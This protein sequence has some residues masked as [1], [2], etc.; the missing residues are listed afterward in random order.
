ML[1][2][3]LRWRSAGLVV[4]A[5]VAAPVQAIAPAPASNES[6]TADQLFDLAER[7]KASSRFT[8]AEAIYRAL[9]RDQGAD[10]R[11]EARFRLGMM[12]ASMRRYRA[13]AQA[14]RGLLDEKPDASRVRLEL[15]R[16]LALMGDEDAA[17]RQLRQAQAAG[18]PPDVAITVGRFANALRTSRQIGGSLEVSIA[19]DSNINRATKATTIDTVIAPLTL[20]QDARAHSGVGVKLSGEAYGRLPMADGV[21]LL[22]R[23]FGQASLYGDSQFD[24]ISTGLSIGP[25]FRSGADRVRPAAGLGRRYYGRDLYA[26]TRTA[27][28]NWL[29]PHGR[30]TQFV[31]DLTISRARYPRNQL[32]TG[33]IYDAS[34]A[35]ERGFSAK[36]G[37]SITLSATRQKARDRGYSTASGGISLLLWRDLG[38]A[39]LYGTVGYRHLNSDAR[40]SLYPR[41]RTEDYVRV[42]VGAS[43]RR[44]AVVGL[45]PIVRVAYERNSS[46]VG[47]YGYRRLA[48]DIGI[49]RAF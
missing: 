40:L 34:V 44:L 45:A 48:V 22:V 26:L 16:V 41:Q 2:R 20:D 32:Q 49:I 37:G 15:A 7:A 35:I 6:L 18:L 42:G 24:D 29:H 27:S 4:L 31:T 17:R 3:F 47:V 5:A 30:R 39:T 1:V 25:E 14:F 46:T 21:N 11:A 28:L 38:A 13:A 9:T 19:P 43:F 8:D 33:M 10:I 23:G 36:A 12:F